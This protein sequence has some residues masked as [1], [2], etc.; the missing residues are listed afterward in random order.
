MP[1]EKN[2]ILKFKQFMKS[3][4]MPY[5]IYADF[6]CSIQKIDGCEINLKYSLT[7]KIGKHIACGY[8]LSTI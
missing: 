3:E 2:E 8:S 6:E 7:T 4:K 5:I 1:F